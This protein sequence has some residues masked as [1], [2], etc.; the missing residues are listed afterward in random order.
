MTGIVR[1]IVHLARPGAAIRSVR[2][3]QGGQSAITHLVRMQNSPDLVVRRFE[4]A[5]HREERTAAVCEAHCLARL[6]TTPIHAPSLVWADPS[7]EHFGMGVVV[8]TRMR[9]KGR[10]RTDQSAW[11]DGIARELAELHRLQP[12]D[13]DR[14]ALPTDPASQ[15][16]W[17]T[18]SSPTELGNIGRAIWPT[19]IEQFA[20]YEPGPERIVHGDYHPGNV[21]NTRGH[22]TAIIDWES[23]M[24]GPPAFDVGYCQM[25]LTVAHGSAVG[26]NF[27]DAY[28]DHAG[29]LP[30]HLALFQL[31]SVVR[32]IPQLGDWIPSWQAQGIDGLK[33]EALE[34]RLA[35]FA[36]GTLLRAVC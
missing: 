5:Y 12:T 23:A 35:R 14:A 34:Q 33:L 16:T 11:V 7:G 18:E 29:G 8:A 15:R 27:L 25:D 9:G 4:N 10:A 28:A 13:E 2:R 21:L 1:D 26:D 19:V 6:A 36:A 20:N 32:A 31:V 24:L 17:L 30:E 22:V 3:L